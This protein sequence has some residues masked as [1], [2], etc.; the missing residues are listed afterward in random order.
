MEYALRC[1]PCRTR[2]LAGDPALPAPAET[3]WYCPSGVSPRGEAVFVLGGE[4]SREA[5]AALYVRERPDL[6]VWVSSGSPAHYACRVFVNRGVEPE[7]VFL[8]YRAIDTLTNFTTMVETFSALGVRRVLLVT[9]GDHMA[10]AAT[11]ARLV[12]GSRGIA[13]T[14]LP[15]PTPRPNEPRRK[16][17]KDALRSV[18]WLATGFVGH[19]RQAYFDFIFRRSAHPLSGSRAPPA[20]PARAPAFA[21]SPAWHARRAGGPPSCPPPPPPPS[22]GSPAQGEPAG[23]HPAGALPARAAAGAASSSIPPRGLAAGA[24]ALARRRAWHVDAHPLTR[25]FVVLS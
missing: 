13:L 22:A 3:E 10:R 8:D 16:V 23:Q 2:Q 15:V 1:A 24:G 17:L 7:R 25:C 12:F 11:I 21:A 14:P 6:P 5:Y 20:A 18:C 19:T 9:T 4:E